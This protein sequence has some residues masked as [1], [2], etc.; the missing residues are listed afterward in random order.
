MT[1]VKE[2]VLVLCQLS[3]KKVNENNATDGFSIREELIEIIKQKKPDFDVEGWV[4]NEELNKIKSDR[5]KKLLQEDV[6]YLTEI[7]K[8]IAEAADK[9]DFMSKDFAEDEEDEML[10]FGQRMSDRVAEFGG[11]WKFIIFF[12]VFFAV[13]ILLNVFIYENKGFD[14]YPF[15]LLN[16]ILSCV[17]AL[18]APIIMM[19]QNRMEEKD[20]ARAI[21]DFKVGLKT[22][23]EI[24]M[25]DEKM[26]HL[27]NKQIFHL[28]ENMELQNEMLENIIKNTKKRK[29]Y[30]KKRVP[31][32]SS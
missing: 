5:I 30:K 4:S 8:K 9:H 2:E 17:A 14:P 12:G 22:E 13:W 10:T 28:H 20:R 27:V 23:I 15:I 19:S 31:E 29:Y 6:G 32:Q 3:G 21:N 11:S 1:K 25:L 7:E 18:Q 26:N 16:L 24:R